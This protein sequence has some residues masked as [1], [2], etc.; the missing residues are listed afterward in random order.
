MGSSVVDRWRDRLYFAFARFHQ[1]SEVVDAVRNGRAV[2]DPALAPAA[3]ERARVIEKG[4]GPNSWRRS[5]G[6]IISIT[7]V[8]SG[9]AIYGAV[10]GDWKLFVA[11]AG[12]AAFY[13]FLLARTTKRQTAQAR[14]AEEVNEQLSRSTE[15]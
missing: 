6:V 14:R 12:Q 7:A 11:F 13:P 4:F 2:H 15:A 1:R 5:P 10:S 8:C 9:V 3:V